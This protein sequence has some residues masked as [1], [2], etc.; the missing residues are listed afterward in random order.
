MCMMCALLCSSYQS[1]EPH[2]QISATAWQAGYSRLVARQVHSGAFS[3]L[4]RTVLSICTA[5]A[6]QM[7]VSS[8]ARVTHGLPHHNEQGCCHGV[9]WWA[10]AILTACSDSKQVGSMC[11]NGSAASRPRRLTGINNQCLHSASTQH[12][13]C[14][15]EQGFNGI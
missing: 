6:C 2:S 11:D 14:A 7:V 1:S 15:T 10:T 3:Q 12:Q 13:T 9:R 8:R 4:W 5:E